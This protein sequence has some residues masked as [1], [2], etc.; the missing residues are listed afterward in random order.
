MKTIESSANPA[1]RRLIDLR[2][3]RHRDEQHRFIIEGLPEVRRA[4]QAGIAIE[5]LFITT[6]EHP[7]LIPYVSQT[8]RI[9]GAAAARAFIRER[10]GDVIAIAEPPSLDL[11]NLASTDL[12]VLA[13]SI[14][15]PGNLGAMLRSA[16]AAG[17]GAVI[18]CD[19]TVDPL[20]T[21]VIRAS[22]GALFTVPI[23]VASLSETIS[24]CHEE[25]VSVVAL[26]PGGTPL[27]NADLTEPM[28]LA[29]GAEHQGISPKLRAAANRLIS[30]PMAGSIDSLNA[31]TALAIGLF[32][33]VRQRSSVKPDA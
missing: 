29:V 31:A 3:R 17:V 21:N 15:K 10:G 6:D 2:K 26:D 13:E 22:L 12:V 8:I 16:D 24:W 11:A 18:A 19:P 4:A 25:G 32:E 27:Y 30:I 14:E 28:A 1:I 9:E 23:A 33:A 7:D 5:T 20:N